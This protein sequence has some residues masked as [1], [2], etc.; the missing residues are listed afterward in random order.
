[1]PSLTLS[2]SKSANQRTGESNFTNDLVQITHL[3]SLFFNDQDIISLS[4]TSKAS[5]CFLRGY[6]LK[7]YYSSRALHRS[8]TGVVLCYVTDVDEDDLKDM[9]N[10]IISI[11]LHDDFNKPLAVGVLP[12]SLTSLTM[13]DEFDCP[14]DLGTLPNSITY[15]DMGVGFDHR[16]YY[17]FHLSACT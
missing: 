5:R 16:L 14:L 6:K 8:S 12:S 9:N 2:K 3:L 7:S 11:V 17:L 4:T 15:L 10:S 13:G 1:M